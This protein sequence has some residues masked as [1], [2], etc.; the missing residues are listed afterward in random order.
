MDIT[1]RTALIHSIVEDCVRNFNPEIL[2]RLK[3]G[4]DPF[5][6]VERTIRQRHR[7][8]TTH[9]LTLEWRRMEGGKSPRQVSTEIMEA[10]YARV[11]VAHANI[12]SS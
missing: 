6:L 8:W 3:R 12:A 10:L 9:P 4:H 5:G 2:A 7:L 1:E 11:K